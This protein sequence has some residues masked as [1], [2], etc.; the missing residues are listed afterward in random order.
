VSDAEQKTKRVI[1]GLAAA[2]M[3]VQVDIDAEHEEVE[4]VTVLGLPVFFRDQGSGRPRVFG[5]P[6]PRW[7]RGP[8]K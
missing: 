7:I 1:R 2:A 3:A 5:V 6:F 4:R 8:R